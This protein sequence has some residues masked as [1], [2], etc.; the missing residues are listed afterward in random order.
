MFAAAAVLTL[1]PAAADA[2]ATGTDSN[3][4]VP[5][6]VSLK[7]AGA[8]GRHGPGLDHR[9]DWIY[10]RA[11]LPLQVTAESG[12]WRRVIDPD[13]EAVWI[14]AQNLNQRRTVYVRD[15][16]ALRRSARNGA[17]VIAYLQPGVIGAITGCEGD[18]RRVAVGGRV[19]WVEADA[20]WAG[21]CTGL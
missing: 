3:L 21:D 8:N 6:F 11:G 13:G 2:P 20:L 18:W 16:A 4:P 14:H 7:A 10:E 17:Q 9:I 5:R 1:G 12:P 15:V 19:G